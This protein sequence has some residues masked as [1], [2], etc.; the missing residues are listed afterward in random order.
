ML[1]HDIGKRIP[2]LAEIEQDFGFRFLQIQSPESLLKSLD[3]ARLSRATIG[4]VA[5]IRFRRVASDIGC[6]PKEFLHFQS[7]P[8]ADR[9]HQPIHMVNV[10]A[11]QR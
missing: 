3:I 5:Q 2:W 8:G 9:F 7:A 4:L 10:H 1:P 6:H 11:S